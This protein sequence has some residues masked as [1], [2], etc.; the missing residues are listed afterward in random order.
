MLLPQVTAYPDG[1]P[2]RRPQKEY[3]FWWSDRILH[4][5]FDA[6]WRMLVVWTPWTPPGKPTAQA[7]DQKRITYFRLKRVEYDDDLDQEFTTSLGLTLA[8]LASA[9]F[10]FMFDLQV[11]N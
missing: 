4:D 3:E 6:P 1:L 8:S 11:Q 2:V 5:P 9:H 7:L 10:K